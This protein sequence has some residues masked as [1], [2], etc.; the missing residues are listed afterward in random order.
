MNCIA[1]FMR[2][3]R[4]L[5]HGLCSDKSTP[6]LLAKTLV[7]ELLTDSQRRPEGILLLEGPVSWNR[8]QDY[9]RPE[10]ISEKRKVI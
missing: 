2:M 7:D 4:G 8:N 1:S 3:R 5:Q 10:A 6:D 9:I